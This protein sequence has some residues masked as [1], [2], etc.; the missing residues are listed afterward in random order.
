ML[1]IEF[2]GQGEQVGLLA[3]GQLEPRRCSIPSIR[4]GTSEAMRMASS[5]GTPA[6]YHVA[7]GA[8]QGERGAARQ[9]AGQGLE[10]ADRV[11]AWGATQWLGDADGP[12]RRWMR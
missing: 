4:A 12:A 5:S 6:S 9:A 10:A 11:L 1:L 8:E 7:H 3:D 2:R